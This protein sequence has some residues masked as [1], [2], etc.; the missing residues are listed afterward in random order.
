VWG[1]QSAKN[2]HIFNSS[3][4]TAR[5]CW[6]FYTNLL[7]LC[8]TYIE[9]TVRTL[10]YLKTVASWP[11]SLLNLWN[12]NVQC[13]VCSL[14]VMSFVSCKKTFMVVI[15]NISENINGNILKYNMWTPT[16]SKLVKQWAL[17]YLLRKIIWAKSEVICHIKPCPC[18][19]VIK[20]IHK[21]NV[22][23]TRHQSV[24]ICRILI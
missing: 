16:H 8:R 20:N 24:L 18:I 13:T 7:E 2:W 3:D 6:T 17:H 4:P 23:Q 5:T 10:V 12:F 1:V 15:L 11:V 22:W 14:D 19:S 21:H 9:R